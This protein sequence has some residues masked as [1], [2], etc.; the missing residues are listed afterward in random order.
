MFGCVAKNDMSMCFMRHV[1]VA[2]LH[3]YYSNKTYL[4]PNAAIVED[5]EAAGILGCP[6]NAGF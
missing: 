6:V 1:T 2:V 5:G 4:C 3:V